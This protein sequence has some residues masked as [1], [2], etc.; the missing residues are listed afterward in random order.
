ML[1]EHRLP[2]YAAQTPIRPLFIAGEF[3]DWIDAQPGIFDPKNGSGGRSR[4]EHLEQTFIDFRCDR[5]PL[6]GDLRCLMPS[7]KRVWSMHSPF[8]RILGWVPAPHQFVAVRGVH[9]AQA[10]GA[11]SQ[12]D[13]T[14]ESVIQFAEL[15]LLKDTMMPGGALELFP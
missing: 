3:D 9:I 5:H 15:H 11:N 10:H 12:I 7:H 13:E 8:F 14:R 1:K 6:V 4:Y 2:D